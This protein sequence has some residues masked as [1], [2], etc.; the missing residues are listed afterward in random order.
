MKGY[1]DFMRRRYGLLLLALA[2]S[3][4]LLFYGLRKS[5]D[6]IPLNT[7]NSALEMRG[8]QFRADVEN[9]VL[10]MSKAG[11]RRSYDLIDMCKKYFPAQTSFSDVRVMMMAARD[12]QDEPLWSA[13]NPNVPAENADKDDVGSGFSLNKTLIS[14]SVFGVVFRPDSS[15]GANRK[16][17][18]I[19][20]CGVLNTNL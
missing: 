9:T 18:K 16:V 2:A 20:S 17:A 19:M 11:A 14:N 15:E 8:R 6:D 3:S 1:G 12:R 7:G 5:D 10:N 4:V 13:H